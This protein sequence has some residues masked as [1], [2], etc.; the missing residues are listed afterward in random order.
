MAMD[1]LSMPVFMERTGRALADGA[2]YRLHAETDEHH[3][4]EKLEEVRYT[5]WHPCAREEQRARDHHERQGVTK[6]PEEAEKGRP[7]AVA[8]PT[9]ERAYRG[10]VVGLECVSHAD[11]RSQPGARQ[12]FEERHV[13]RRQ[14]I[15]REAGGAA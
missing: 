1:Q 14:T 10:E 9:D 7:V 6:A 12:Q 15:L 3:A 13:R 11:E 2:A 5:R 8:L 4:D